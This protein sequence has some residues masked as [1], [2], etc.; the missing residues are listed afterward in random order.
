MHA[1]A[2]CP[3]RISW[4]L[5]FVFS[6]ILP[7][8]NYMYE[9][10]IKRGLFVMSSFF[11]L[12]YLV[13]VFNSPIFGFMIPILWITSIFDS[14]H[15]RRRILDGECVPDDVE[16][17]VGFI[18]K[19][20]TYVITASLIVLFITAMHSIGMSYYASRLIQF[21]FP[22]ALIAI[23]FYIARNGKHGR[24]KTEK[25]DSEGNL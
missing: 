12:V 16:D 1:S 24:I 19:H 10:L 23:V 8:I 25:D 21:F 6:F 15:I 3:K 4:G 11:L 2:S 20:K 14:F 22:L 7:G 18:R 9:G 17:I 5:M 13:S